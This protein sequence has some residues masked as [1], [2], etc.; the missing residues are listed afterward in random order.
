MGNGADITQVTFDH[1]DA[2]ILSQTET[3]VVVNVSPSSVNGP[4]NVTVISQTV[5]SFKEDAFTFI[6]GTLRNR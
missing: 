3:E 6:P 1:Q 5:N 2:E 4:V